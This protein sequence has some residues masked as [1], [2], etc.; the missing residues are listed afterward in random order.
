[1]ASGPGER[2]AVLLGNCPQFHIVFY[3]ILKLGAVYVPVNR[4]SR[5]TSWPMN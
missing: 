3:A 4:C 5:N 2:V 1:M